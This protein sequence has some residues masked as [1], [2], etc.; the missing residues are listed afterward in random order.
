MSQPVPSRA[1]DVWVCDRRAQS[2]RLGGVVFQGDHA[3]DSGGVALRGIQV[4]AL[5]AELSE[6]TL[7]LL[8]LTNPR[9]DLRSPPLQQAQ[10]MSTW[11]AAAFAYLQ[12]L[13]DVGQGQPDCLG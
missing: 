9:R 12:D 10:D 1:V 4:L 5:R 2:A 6:V 11:R 3:A 7:Q 13:S 8:E